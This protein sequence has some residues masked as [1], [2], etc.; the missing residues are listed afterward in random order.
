MD[1][2][3]TLRESVSKRIMKI[4]LDEITIGKLLK[5]LGL[6]FRSEL[7]VRKIRNRTKTDSGTQAEHA[8]AIGE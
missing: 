2:E 4:V 3:I 8:K 5:M 6:I 7:I 1:D